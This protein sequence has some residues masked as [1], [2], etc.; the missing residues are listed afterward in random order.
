MEPRKARC[1]CNILSP[2]VLDCA[3]KALQGQ[4]QPCEVWCRTHPSRPRG[5]GRRTTSGDPGAPPQLAALTGLHC[6]HGQS[7]CPLPPPPEASPRWG[8][9]SRSCPWPQPEDTGPGIPVST[10][11]SSTVTPLV[12]P[13][14]HPQHRSLRRL[15]TGQ[16]RA[17][18]LAQHRG[19]QTQALSPGLTLCSQADFSFTIFNNVG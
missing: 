12:G 19:L 16:H 2:L 11:P 6:G 9:N 8:R 18:R 10:P 4:L 13:Q 3:C 15:P 17:P 7:V 1:P 5:G 14:G